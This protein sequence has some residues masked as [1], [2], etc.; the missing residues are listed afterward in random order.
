MPVKLIM[1][2]IGK[3]FI[4]IPWNNLATRPARLDLEGLH[5]VVQPLATKEEWKH[6]I[7][8][9]NDL[10]SLEA[11]LVEHI[12]EVIEQ[13]LE[14]HREKAASEGK[15]E[16]SQDSQSWMVGLTTKVLDNIQVSIKNIHIRLEDTHLFREPLAMGVTL[17]DLTVATTNTLWQ[18]TFIDR[19]QAQN[20]DLPL[21][22][23]IQLQGFG[24]YCNPADSLSNLVGSKED[25]PAKLS[26]MQSLF[27]AEAEIC[28]QYARHY[29]LQPITITAKLKQMRKK[30]QESDVEPKF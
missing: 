20:R 16:A 4:K 12:S 8:K 24:V 15:E 23:R 3:L 7:S 11:K 25:S 30:R 26:H 21:N 2:R 28:A 5:I 18:D 19:T 29:L 13:Q 9:K 22:K 27:D 6:L 14:E 17:K 10:A 1:G